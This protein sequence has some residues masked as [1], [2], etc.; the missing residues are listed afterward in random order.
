M[1]ME[2]MSKSCPFDERPLSPSYPEEVVLL[3]PP[4]ALSLEVLGQHSDVTM[5]TKRE[6]QKAPAHSIL[7]WVCHFQ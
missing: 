7:Y 3:P 1:G 6:R 2:M 4:S 5:G